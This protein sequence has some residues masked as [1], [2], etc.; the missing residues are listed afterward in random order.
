MAFD[1]M[2]YKSLVRSFLIGLV[3]SVT[4]RLSLANERFLR[5]HGPPPPTEDEEGDSNEET[6]TSLSDV[7]LCMGIA[8]WS[9]IFSTRQLYQVSMSRYA[10][11]GILAFGHVIETNID[12]SGGD[13]PGIPSYH[14]LIDYTYEHDGKTIQIRKSFTTNSLLE[15]GFANVRILVLPEDPTSGLLLQDWEARHSR[16]QDEGGENSH[17]MYLILSLGVVFVVTS[18]GGA[19]LAVQRLPVEL[20]TEGWICLATTS[21]LIWPMSFYLNKL[22][23]SSSSYITCQTI[24][25]KNTIADAGQLASGSYFWNCDEHLCAKF[26]GMS[27]AETYRVSNK[28][29]GEEK[30]PRQDQFYIVCVPSACDVMDG[31]TSIVS[32]SSISNTS[33]EENS[34]SDTEVNLN[35]TKLRESRIP[36]S[37]TFLQT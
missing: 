21:F 1:V 25:E 26:C 15:K 35:A 10:K 5:S 20:Q 2:T 23:D 37:L 18:I 3:W 4:L 29:S 36:S 16:E 22:W 8:F 30:V 9:T 14:A 12:P 17:M 19:V 24:E 7:W 27:T 33:F 31:N 28:G 34:N 6:Q 32:L 13:T 11:D